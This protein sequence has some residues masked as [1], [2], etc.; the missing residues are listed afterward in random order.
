MW[1]RVSKDQLVNIEQIKELHATIRMVPELES[2]VVVYR[3]DVYAVTV[4]DYEFHLY[5]R[6]GF[7]SPQEAENAMND[8]MSV[9][10]SMSRSNMIMTDKYLEE[11][12]NKVPRGEKR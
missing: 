12:A 11:L 9:L 6:I 3:G 7:P 2:D 5:G 4:E 10:A 1:Y 8:I